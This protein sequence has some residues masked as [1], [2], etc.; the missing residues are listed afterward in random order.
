MIMSKPRRLPNIPR[1]HTR[2]FI[3]KHQEVVFNPNPAG[4]K[5]NSSKQQRKQYSTQPTMEQERLTKTPSTTFIFSEPVNATETPTLQAST[6]EHHS[7]VNT[8]ERTESPAHSR[9]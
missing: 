8:S 5:D 1:P 6:D 9:G 7:T 3:S 2:S 4:K